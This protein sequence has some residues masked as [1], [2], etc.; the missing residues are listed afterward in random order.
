MLTRQ[1]V[2][3]FWRPARVAKNG[4][5]CLEPLRD[6]AIMNF[7]SSGLRL[8]EL[9]LWMWRMWISTRVGARVRKGERTRCR[10]VC[11]R[12]RP[13]SRYRAAANVHQ[14]RFS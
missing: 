9:A 10:L 13:I 2:E 8:S 7:Y 4:P 6:V 5:P 1:Q 14:G 11:R 12:W 3:N